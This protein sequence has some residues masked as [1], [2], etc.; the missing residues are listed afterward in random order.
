VNPR[1]CFL[2]ERGLP[3]RLNPVISEAAALLQERGASVR[4]LYPEEELTRLDGLAVDADLYL[5]K[6]NTE[7]ALSLA[8]ALERLGARV[9]NTCAATALA[10]DKVLAAAMLL[11]AGIPTPPSFAAGRPKQLAREIGRGSLVLKPARG[12]YGAGIAVIDRHAALPEGDTYPDMVFAQR[13]VD[14]ARADLKLYGVG[15]EI[16]GVRKPFGPTSF[17]VRG[18]AVELEPRLVNLA[19][20]CGSVFSLELF[21]V[22]VAESP[23]GPQ[24]IDV[25]AFPGFR[26]VPDAA[27]RL[28]EYVLRAA[29][30]SVGSHS[31]GVGG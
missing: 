5:L 1:I 6:S 27:R 29:K 19:Q 7:L 18:Q 22:D 11:R 24:I 21:G 10:R 17:L 26:G 4:L 15:D 28:A 12:H 14:E 25:N 31:R 3:P 30:D 23:D 9:V 20:Q 2:L 13:Y 16:F 8:S